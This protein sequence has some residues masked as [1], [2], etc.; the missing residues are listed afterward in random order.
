MCVMSA[1]Y[2]SWDKKWPRVM[3]NPVEPLPG[4]DWNEKLPAFDFAK[5]KQEMVKELEAAKQ[6]DIAEGNPD[7]V[8]PDKAKL[9]ERVKELE[10]LL[11]THPEF[12]IV[13]GST[14]EPGTYRVID[15]KLYKVIE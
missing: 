3:I 4:Y 8:D 11:D 7:C 15:K 6:Q 2:D 1:V 14:L 13:K 10:A 9:M 12:V 5:I